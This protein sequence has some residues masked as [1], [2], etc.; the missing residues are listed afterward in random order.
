V[1]AKRDS[2]RGKIYKARAEIDSGKALPT[3]S[4]IKAYRPDSDLD[5]LIVQDH[6]LG[7]GQTRRQQMS[8]IWRLLARFP[9]SQDILIYTPDEVREWKQSKN[10]VIAT[11]LREGRLVY[12]RA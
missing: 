10:H 9:V 12:E 4:E 11:A 8:K 7:P 1:K 2:Q 5:F 6:A 3:I